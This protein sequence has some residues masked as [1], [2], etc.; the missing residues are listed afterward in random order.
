MEQSTRYLV[1]AKS[2]DSFKNRLDK[3]W[4]NQELVYGN[5]KSEI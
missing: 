4:K 5:Y 2:L 1:C 3:W